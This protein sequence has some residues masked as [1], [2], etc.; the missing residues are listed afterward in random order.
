MPRMCSSQ[1]IY[2]AYA[3]LEEEHGL[4]R[5]AMAVYDRAVAHVAAEDKLEV[6]C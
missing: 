1:D 3:R 4:A 2:M 6:L 5:H